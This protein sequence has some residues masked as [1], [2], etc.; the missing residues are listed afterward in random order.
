MK[1]TG[2]IVGRLIVGCVLACFLTS[3]LHA[4]IPQF[5]SPDTNDYDGGT[6]NYSYSYTYMPPNYGTNLWIEF[7]GKTNL[8]VYFRLHN[9]TNALYY[10]I[11]EK[12]NLNDPLWIPPALYPT[13]GTAGTNETI[14]DPFA[15][16]STAWPPPPYPAILDAANSMF[17]LA[18]GATNWVAIYPGGGNSITVTQ[19]SSTNDL[20]QN[21]TN[22]MESYTVFSTPLAV[23]CKI[24][25][26]AVYG[27]D[28]TVTGGSYSNSTVT[29]TIPAQ[30]PYLSPP[31]VISP[32]IKTNAA[33]ANDVVSLTIGLALGGNYIIDSYAYWTTINIS[34]PIPITTVTSI[35]YP[36]E[37]G[38]SYQSIQNALMLSVN[39]PS[40]DPNNFI[41]IGT[42]SSGALT[43][44]NWSGVADVPG[45]VEIA[46]AQTT[47]NGF[48]Q[49]DTYFG[50]DA[51]LIDKLSADGSEWSAGWCSL[52]NETQTETSGLSGIC[53]DKSGSFGGGLVVATGSGNIWLIQ[54]DT[55]GNA[56]PTL[57]TNISG[58]QALGGIIT[59]TNDVAKWGPWAG[60]ILTGDTFERNI[61]AIDTNGIVTTYNTINPTFGNG[62]S[63]E[64]FCLIP[65]NQDLYFIDALNNNLLK[66]SRTAL[67]PYVGD[68][69]IISSNTFDSYVIYGQVF[70]IAWDPVNSVFK[71]KVIPATGI[72]EDATF[73]PINLPSQ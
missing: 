53:L 21:V 49:G 27:V 46:T 33:F 25:G 59:L 66:I 54:S 44:A 68:L 26:S 15:A 22:Y 61:Y 13:L 14:F 50:D 71:V 32:L 38:I 58:S 42:N 73:A 23:T 35:P 62:I 17:F 69:V 60:K 24:Y 67:A 6:N 40:G 36:Y 8:D 3:N 65:T 29:M 12:Y 28:F 70:I 18:Y 52:T 2:K 9:T 56:K 34:R 39:N 55:N 51:G 37:A 48:T 19:P 43:M 41:L 5:P 20:S 64:S 57:L 63:P 72:L 30:R 1:A 45:E 47:A 31:L 10:Q 11:L 4:Q 7:F 16:G